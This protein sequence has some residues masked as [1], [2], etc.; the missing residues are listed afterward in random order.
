MVD[1][2][3]KKKKIYIYINIYIH[4]YTME[5]YSDIKENVGHPRW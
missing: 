4:T 1:E 5:N 3:I 2:W